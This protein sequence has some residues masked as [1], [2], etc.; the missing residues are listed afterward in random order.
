MLAERVVRASEGK[1][2][3]IYCVQFSGLLRLPSISHG[4][5]L[6]VCYKK[7]AG[8]SACRASQ[9]LSGL[10]SVCADM[11]LDTSSLL[12]HMDDMVRELEAYKM[13]HDS[14]FDMVRSAA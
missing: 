9:A 8:S 12:G 6:C 10:E 2:T 3:S 11:Q 5:G 1:R 13:L 7:F 14:V 4:G